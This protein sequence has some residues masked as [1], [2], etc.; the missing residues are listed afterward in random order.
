MNINAPWQKSWYVKSVIEPLY[1]DSTMK[2]NVAQI[3]RAEGKFL[4]ESGDTTLSEQQLG[5]VRC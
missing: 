2:T 1:A 3:S 5:S 4:E